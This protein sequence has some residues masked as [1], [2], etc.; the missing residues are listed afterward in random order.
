VRDG[1]PGDV[2]AIQK[3]HD[4]HDLDT[5]C[6]IIRCAAHIS[7]Q[8]RLWDGLRVVTNQNGTPIAYFLKKDAGGRLQVREV[9]LQR[10]EHCSVLLQAIGQEARAHFLHEIGIVA[11]PSHAFVQY[12]MRYKSRHEMRLTQ[13]EGGMMALVNTAETLESM[14]P[15]WEQALVSGGLVEDRAEVTLLVDRKPY[16]VRANRGAIDVAQQSGV[17]KFGVSGGDLM[18]LLSG[19]RY[20]EEVFAQ[21]RRM[22]SAEGRALLAAL[23]PKRTPFVWPMDRF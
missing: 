12:L 21:Q 14:I 11:P 3:M 10:R 16:R 15:E 2:Q 7:H 5:A 13:N 1:K 20:F 22:I 9:G 19:Y 4:T 6:S 8:W 18:L 23:F 17:N